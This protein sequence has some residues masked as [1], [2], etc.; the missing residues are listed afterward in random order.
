MTEPV[1]DSMGGYRVGIER[2]SLVL[3]D[4]CEERGSEGRKRCSW[5]VVEPSNAL[6][7]PALELKRKVEF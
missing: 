7:E 1:D 5:S 4:E 3:A 6:R 2:A